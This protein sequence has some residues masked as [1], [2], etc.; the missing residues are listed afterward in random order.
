[1]LSSKQFGFAKWPVFC[2]EKTVTGAVY[3]HMHENLT[4]QWV[5]DGYTFQLDGAPPYY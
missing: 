1:M 2:L 3:L 4:M 5:L